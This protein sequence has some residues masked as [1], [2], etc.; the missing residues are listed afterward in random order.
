MGKQADSFLIKECFPLKPSVWPDQSWESSISYDNDHKLH[1]RLVHSVP[2]SS[3]VVGQVGQLWVD[4]RD[5]NRNPK[6]TKLL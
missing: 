4:C 2:S 3:R 5:K 6:K 1:P